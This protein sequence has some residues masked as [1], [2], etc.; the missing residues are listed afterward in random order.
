MTAPEVTV[1]IAVH[2]AMPYLIAC[3]DSLVRQT[4]G[5]ARMEVI[6]VDDGSTDG[7]GTVLDGYAARHPGLFTVLHQPDSGG[8][9]AAANRG[10]ALARGRYVLFPGARDWLGADALARMVTAA[11]DWG[12]DVLLP[13]RIGVHGR[14]VPPVGLGASAAS[15]G[16]ADTALAEALTGT[17]LFRLDL[18]GRHGLVRDEELKACADQPFTLAAWLHARRI[19]VL[20]DRDHHLVLRED[21]AG[22]TRRAGV[23]ERLRGAAAALSVAAEL[24][25]EGAE[26]DAIRAR[27]F[28]REVSSL[29]RRDFP[30]HPAGRQDELCAGVA[31]L[32]ERFGAR[33]VYDRLP[34]PDRLRLEL[35]A[36]GRAD[37]LRDLIRY[38]AAHGDPPVLVEGR[39]RYAGYPAFRDPGLGLADGLFLLTEAA[40]PPAAGPPALARRLWRG[41]VP[42]PARRRLSP[43][44][45]ALR[46]AGARR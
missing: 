40:A 24:A 30:R 38:E 41:A 13:T 28:G 16:F 37:A 29:L 32:V 42:A 19:S 3:L 46:A 1:V 23:R 15:V 43:L 26:L 12:S 2:N 17:E 18:I 44:V 33:E 34:V 31:G 27:Y 21:G 36:T 5:P 9:A 6:A 25:A 7:G 10:L 45:G 20:A 14:P 35:A 8:P 11:D 4:I 39:R 22:A